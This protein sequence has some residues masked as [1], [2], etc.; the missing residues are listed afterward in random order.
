MQ[1]EKAIIRC[2][3]GNIKFAMKI[4]AGVCRRSLEIYKINSL[5]ASRKIGFLGRDAVILYS[6]RDSKISVRLGERVKDE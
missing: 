1:N 5:K 2:E 6:R 4:I 3:K